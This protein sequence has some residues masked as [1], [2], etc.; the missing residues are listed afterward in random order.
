MNSVFTK[1]TIFFCI[2]S[3]S[4]LLAVDE[5]KSKTQRQGCRL[6]SRSVG[7]GRRMFLW[8]LD[9]LCDTTSGWNFHLKLEMLTCN[10]SRSLCRSVFDS[11]CV[12]ICAVV[13]PL[14]LCASASRFRL[15]VRS[16]VFLSSLLCGCLPCI[17]I[18]AV[19][20]ESSQGF[21]LVPL[22]SNLGLEPLR[23]FT[24][25]IQGH[26]A[27]QRTPGPHEVCSWCSE[28]FTRAP[29]AGHFVAPGHPCTNEQTQTFCSP[30]QVN[31]CLLVPLRWHVTCSSLPLL[32]QCLTQI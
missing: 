24:F 6:W 26:R 17:S 9:R 30:V 22:T 23:F 2:L 13:F 18:S 16:R 8:R 25:Y 10:E 20:R 27:R 29:A 1:N 11:C 3:T 32:P 7:G 14:R 12:P 28:T 31:D 21:V 15:K 19:I 4:L 5:G